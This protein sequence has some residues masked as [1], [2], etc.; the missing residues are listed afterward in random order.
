MELQPISSKGQTHSEPKSNQLFG[1]DHVSMNYC[2]LLETKYTLLHF[3]VLIHLTCGKLFFSKE[4]RKTSTNDTM[5]QL[6]WR[7]KFICNHCTITPANLTCQLSHAS[8]TATTSE[9]VLSKQSVNA[10]P[11]TPLVVVLWIALELA[12]QWYPESQSQGK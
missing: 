7:W 10:I 5:V 9:T 8:L 6:C 4:N 11:Q 1:A 3:R 12:L 2:Q